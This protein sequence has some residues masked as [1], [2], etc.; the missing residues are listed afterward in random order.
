M[1]M[2]N[3]VKK[4]REVKGL[5]QKEFADMCGVTQR[6][7]QNW[8]A[9]KNALIMP[10]IQMLGYDVF[11][12]MEVIPEMDC[13]IA[14]KK[15]EK[16]DY[17]ILK[18]G[19]PIILFE[20]KHWQQDLDLHSTQLQRYFVA[21]K[22]RFGVL[23]NGIVY[24]F[25]TDLAKPNI[26]D[27]TPFLEVDMEHLKDAQI[28]ELKK[29]HKSYFDIDN[30]LSTANELKYLS[31]LKAQIK[32]VISQ[33]S[34]KFVRLFAKRVYD[35]VLSQKMLEQF[36]DLVR[37]AFAS[38]IND[39]ISERLNAA[40]QT[41]E[42]DEQKPEQAKDTD[43]TATVNE[44]PK[45]GIVTTEEEL[46]GFYIVKSILRGEIAA[47]RITYRDAQ[48]YFAIFIDD[49]NRKPVCR[50]YFN[51]S[52]NKRIRIF[53]ADLQWSKHEIQTLDDIF[54]LQD[55]LKQAVAKYK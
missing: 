7:V 55:E 16:I 6:T 27:D 30:I 33:P 9:T 50:L 42:T 23:T 43:K 17:A 51:N 49:N 47:D 41:T 13:D 18:D 44:K 22:A 31:E 1:T 15:G 37:R 14:K 53:G 8:E 52:D 45:D 36:T 12:P 29:F 28:E 54:N 20:C 5:T 40:M 46:E 38:Q 19:E 21:S 2:D 3:E 48:S 26:M 25:Y 24:R 11:N 35:G 39:V 34:E 10:F 4:V 32:A